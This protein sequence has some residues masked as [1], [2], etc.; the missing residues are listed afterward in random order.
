V[1]IAFVAIWT[2]R[3]V[4][5]TFVLFA[6]SHKTPIKELVSFHKVLIIKSQSL[7]TKRLAIR[8][9][10]RLYNGLS[11]DLISFFCCLRGYTDNVSSCYIRCLCFLFTMPT[12]LNRSY[13]VLNYCTTS[14]TGP[15]SFTKRLR[16]LIRFINFAGI[17][18]GQCSSLPS[19]MRKGR[20]IWARSASRPHYPKLYLK[21]PDARLLSTHGSIT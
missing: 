14:F 13:T 3:V 19:N 12:S 7:C 2:L 4:Q 8:W 20:R 21:H 15:V 9:R 18:Y 17:F 1:P 5:L 6:F 10:H 11:S 16:L